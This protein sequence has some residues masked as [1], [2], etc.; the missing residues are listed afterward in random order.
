MD[1]REARRMAASLRTDLPTLD[2]H[3]LYP[4]EALEKLELFL[5]TMIE[6][7]ETEFAVVYGVGTGE[8][9]KTVLAH[10]DKHPAVV[11]RVEEAGRCI[12]LL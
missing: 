7:G 4:Q 12:V 8:L 6:R 9:G 11:D 1:T 5:Y 2:L 10:L 3:G